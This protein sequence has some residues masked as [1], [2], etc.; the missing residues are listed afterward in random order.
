MT[1]QLEASHF[2]PP[3]FCLPSCISTEKVILNAQVS[4]KGAPVRVHTLTEKKDEPEVL[5]FLAARPVYT[6]FMSGLIRDNGLVSPSNRGTFYA[7]RDQRGQL[8]GVALIGH[9][10]LVE[11]RTEAALA[12]FARQAQGCLAAH[13]IIG[14]QEMIERF[15]HHYAEEGKRP[16]LVSCSLLLEQRS[17][18]EAFEGVPELRAATQED[19]PLLLPVNAQLSIE[20]CGVNPLERDPQGF[21]SR[22]AQRIDRGRI[23]VW[24][25]DRRLIFKADILAET[26]DAAYL[27]GIYVSPEDRGK[28]YGQRCMS[29][30]A[31]N[32]LARTNTLCLLVNEKNRNAREF[33]SRVG[34]KLCAYFDSI[35]LH[36][37]QDAAAV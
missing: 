35:Y 7:C 37:Q 21:S 28:R 20:E 9:A 17:A 18:L 6:V 11:T 23:W 19:L 25:K 14:E 10:T 31:R 1:I 27:E 3:I 4:V 24:V 26:E 22:L 15:W 2:H 5:N 33:Y 32:L 8:V 16:R 36:P 30:L 13:I 12:A 29:Q 34:Y